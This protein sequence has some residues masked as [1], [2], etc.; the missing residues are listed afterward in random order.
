MSWVGETCECNLSTQGS[1]L[2][3]RLGTFAAFFNIVENKG[4]LAVKTLASQSRKAAANIGKN[5]GLGGL[6]IGDTC[7]I[8]STVF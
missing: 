3:C 6:V 5:R 4:Y 2:V 1:K 8:R 7:F